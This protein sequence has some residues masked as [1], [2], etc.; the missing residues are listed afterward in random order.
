MVD[1]TEVDTQVGLAALL[2]ADWMHLAAVD[3]ELVD[4]AALWPPAGGGLADVVAAHPFVERLVEIAVTSTRP[5]VRAT[6]AGRPDLDAGLYALFGDDPHPVV[7]A[8]VA[9]N[10]AA[11]G[12]IV[13][14]LCRDPEATVRESAGREMA[15]RRTL[16]LGLSLASSA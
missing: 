9:A 10:H 3:D 15:R 2:D 14:R 1:Q 16:E 13:G 12:A 7:R 4:D 5:Q 8:R 11:P 6:V